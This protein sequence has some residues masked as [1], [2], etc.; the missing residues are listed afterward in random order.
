MNSLIERGVTNPNSTQSWQLRLVDGE[1]EI[2]AGLYNNDENRYLSTSEQRE[3]LVNYH[4]DPQV[5]RS[6]RD[7][8]CEKQEEDF[9]D[10]PTTLLMVDLTTLRFDGVIQWIPCVK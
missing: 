9:D 10:V 4:N 7:A 1:Y 3:W 6:L 2:R 8:V 5:R